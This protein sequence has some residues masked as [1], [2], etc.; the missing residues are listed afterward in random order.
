MKNFLY[1]FGWTFMISFIIYLGTK[2]QIQLQKEMS[3]TMEPGK[4]LSFSV[5]FPIIIGLFLGLPRLINKIKQQ[6]EW[7]INWM[8]LLVI[9]LPTLLVIFIY[10]FLY[11]IPESILPF[12]PEQIFLRNQTIHVVAGVVF[13]Y[14]L[15]DSL[16]E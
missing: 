3:Q 16:K 5:L 10:L 11:Q 2:Y 9:G 15:L 1:Y 12:I 13:G 7:T 14:V 8:K 4:Y 6:K